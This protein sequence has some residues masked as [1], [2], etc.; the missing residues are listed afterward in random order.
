M[1]IV[2]DAYEDSLSLREARERYFVANGF[3][4]DGGYGA[5]WVRVK[6]GPVPMWILNSRSRMRAVPFHDLHHVLTGYRTTFRGECEIGGWELASGCADHAAAWFLNLGV[7]GAGLLS[8]PVEVW[9]AFHRGRRSGNLYRARFDETLLERRLGEVRHQLR[10][11]DAPEVVGTPSAI[12][13][14][15]AFAAWSFVGV[16][17]FLSLILSSPVTLPVLAVFSRLGRSRKT[18]VSRVAEPR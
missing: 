10:L 9:R 12:S 4:S 16:P 17:F 5:T 6:V 13:D 7:F 14:R 15:I 11:D 2:R 1:R 3:G 18:T 8:A